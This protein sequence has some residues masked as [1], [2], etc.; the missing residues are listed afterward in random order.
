MFEC[1]GFNTWL[2]V[3]LANS[4]SALRCGVTKHCCFAWTGNPAA[5]HEAILQRKCQQSLS[6]GFITRRASPNRLKLWSCKGRFSNGW[7]KSAWKHCYIRLHVHCTV[8][9]INSALVS[10]AWLYLIQFWRISNCVVYGTTPLCKN[11]SGL[12]NTFFVSMHDLIFCIWLGSKLK[13]QVCFL[14]VRLS[15]NLLPKE[16]CVFSVD[17]CEL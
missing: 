4:S 3:E 9:R 12:S 16:R 10:A 14:S 7:L 1:P 2:L 6:G 5:V 17:S 11:V 15:W 13:P 8:D